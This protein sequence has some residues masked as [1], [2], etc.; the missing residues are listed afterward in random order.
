M[1]GDEGTSPLDRRLFLGGSAVTL[2]GAS[3][4][5][6]AQ[7]PQ[8]PKAGE[9][10][11]ARL[12][13]LIAD[14]ITGFDLAKVPPLAIE[15]ARL[16]FIDTVGVMLAGSR[17]EPA[18]IV[19]EMV[20]A[21]G[22][23]P[24]ASVVGHS[25][26]TSPQLAALA[27]GVASHALD[28]DLTYS[29][30]P[31]GRAGHP[32]AAAARREQRRDAGRDARGLHRR[33]RGLLAARA[34]PTRTTTA[35]ASGTAPAPSGD[36]GGGRLRAALKVKAAAIPDVLGISVSMAAGVNANYGTMT[37][38][39][40]AGQAARNAIVAALLGARGFTAN[41]AAIEGRGG[42]ARTFARGLEWKRR[43]SRSRPPSDLA[44]Y[45]FQAQALSVRRR[46][47]YRHRCRAQDP[48]DAGRARG[49]HHRDQGGHHE[50]RRQPRQRAV[51]DQYRGGQVQSAICRGLRA[52]QGVPKLDA[53]DEAAIKDERVKALAQHGVDFDRPGIRRRGRGLSDPVGGLAHRRQQVSSRPGTTPVAPASIRCRR[54]RSRTSSSTAPRRWWTPPQPGRSSRRSHLGRAEKLRRALAAAAA[55]ITLSPR[56]SGAPRKRRARNPYSPLAVI[57]SGPPVSRPE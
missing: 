14:F 51:S 39:L 11:T 56:H 42:F 34:A 52:G 49:G 4:G 3:T 29:A 55:G 30:R 20:Q 32:G 5:A 13:P 35:A 41:A 12:S 10:A 46:D 24:A 8:A 33:F 1:V 31:A 47:P 9:A 50:I 16:A 28:F 2:L 21:E 44:E 36:C 23:K 7:Q 37:K 6:L 45:G 25:L 57:C 48:R 17:S 43:R 26:R 19:R 18:E 40:H 53:F 27:N 15:R 22:A 38:P 54:R